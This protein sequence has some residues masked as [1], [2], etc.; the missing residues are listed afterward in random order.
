M[1]AWRDGQMSCAHSGGGPER[2]RR[3]HSP[4]AA[5]VQLC[6]DV[7]P[8]R[9][10]STLQARRARRQWH[11]ARPSCMRQAL[12]GAGGCSNLRQGVRNVD[13]ANPS[14]SA[15]QE[16]QTCGSSSDGRQPQRCAQGSCRGCRRNP[17]WPRPAKRGVTWE[18][19]SWSPSTCSLGS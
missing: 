3:A 7:A 6:V 5:V 4:T 14:T 9:R 8:H 11:P 13:A 18:W 19:A 12:L 2:H 1:P 16:R 15:A 10:G 17:M